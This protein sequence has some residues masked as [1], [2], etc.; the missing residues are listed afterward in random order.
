[1]KADIIELKIGDKCSVDCQT[2]GF[3][4]EGPATIVVIKEEAATVGATTESK[5][6]WIVGTDGVGR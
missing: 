5:S 2:H 1:M 3:A 6:V 4:I